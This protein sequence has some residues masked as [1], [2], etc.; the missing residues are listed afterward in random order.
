ML[1]GLGMINSINKRAL[2]ALVFLLPIAN[3]FAAFNTVPDSFIGF[4]GSTLYEYSAAGTALQSITNTNNSGGFYGP[5]TIGTDGK[6]YILRVDTSGSN[7][8]Y[9]VFLDVYD[10]TQGWSTIDSTGLAT[11]I[12]YDYAMV[13]ASNGLIFIGKQSLVRVD[14]STA[15]PTVTEVPT[16]FQFR[17]LTLG[18]NG[19]LYGLYDTAS[20]D[21]A[22]V[23]VDPVSLRETAGI[24]LS[25]I[26][27]PKALA[28]NQTGEYF[29]VNTLHELFKFSADGVQIGISLNYGANVSGSV[30]DLAITSA[31][32]V[33]VSHQSSVLYISDENLSPGNVSGVT[34]NFDQLYVS[35]N[36]AVTWVGGNHPAFAGGQQNYITFAAGQLAEYDNQGGLVNSYIVNNIP[37]SGAIALA[38]DGLLYAMNIDT[39]GGASPYPYDIEVFDAKTGTWT[40]MGLTGF[41]VSD[42][43]GGY[44]LAVM[45]NYLLVMKHQTGTTNPLNQIIA[46]DRSNGAQT[47]VGNT[48][49]QFVD[50]YVSSDKKIYALIDTNSQLLVQ[51]FDAA[52]N[53]VSISSLS[54]WYT[55]EA[56]V[57]NGQGE[58][59]VIS[60]NQSTI[61][62]YPN[63]FTSNATN[64][65]PTNFFN[66]NSIISSN[67]KDMTLTVAGDLISSFTGGEIMRI[68]QTLTNPQQLTSASNNNDVFLS[69]TLPPQAGSD[70]DNDGMPDDW[71]LAHGLSVCAD[72]SC[73]DAALD[74]D[75]DGLINIDEYTNGTDP[76]NPDSDGDFVMDGLEVGAGLNP[77]VAGDTLTDSDSDGFTDVQEY[78]AGTNAQDIASFPTT[79]T[80]GYKE[81]FEAGVINN[82]WSSS[83]WVIDHSFSS[84]GLTSVKAGPNSS[85]QT[86]NLRLE[87]QFAQAGDIYFDYQS[88]GSKLDVLVDSVL[89]FSVEQNEFSAHAVSVP[90]G[91]HVVEFNY[92]GNEI[93]PTEAWIDNVRYVASAGF[94]QNNGSFV[95]QDGST[96]YEISAEGVILKRVPI[97]TPSLP[98]DLAVTIDRRVAL[99]EITDGLYQVGLKF[100]DP[101]TAVWS[102]SRDLAGV[103]AWDSQIRQRGVGIL[104]NNIFV[105]VGD[106]YNSVLPHGASTSLGIYDTIADTVTPFSFSN[107]G[108]RDAIVG[109]DGKLY[110]LRSNYLVDVFSSTLG[111]LS[112]LETLDFACNTTNTCSGTVESIAVSWNG[113]VYLSLSATSNVLA[114]FT[115]ADSSIVYYTP[116]VNIPSAS[117]YEDIDINRAGTIFMSSSEGKILITDSSL[118]KAK[119]IKMNRY[120]ARIFSAA[121]ES[122][123]VDA[124]NDGM[125]DG[126]E[127]F[128][129]VNDPAADPDGD[130][131]SNL[132]EY[133]IYTNPIVADTD[134]DNL[135]DGLELA[136][137]PP[138]DPLNPDSD[139]DGLLD[140]DEVSPPAGTPATLP[141]NP[142]TD[143]DGLMD[144]AE[145]NN[146]D[147]NL[148]SD[149]T[150]TDTDGDQLDDKFEV[151]NGIS[152]NKTDSDG[153]QLPDY[154][155][156]NYQNTSLYPNL[157]IDTVLK[158]QALNP[159]QDDTTAG[160]GTAP[161]YDVDGLS[162]LE[163][164]QNNTCPNDNDSDND[165][166]SDGSE[167]K[168]YA[169]DPNNPDT[170]G[171]TYLDGLEISFAT[172]PK[173]AASPAATDDP[174]M[175]GLTMAQEAITN[176]DP[177]NAADPG[178]T[179]DSDG[180]GYTNVEE[181]QAGTDP[182]DAASTPGML[183]ND[184]DGLTN[185]QEDQLGTDKNDINDPGLFA[186]SDAD[187]YTN[188]EESIAGTDP[189]DSNSFPSTSPTDTD[190][191]GYADA[192]E[193]KFGTAP[194]D[195]KSPAAGDDP[196]N[197]GLTM[198]Q[199]TILGT[200][201]FNSAS[202]GL[203]ADSDGD[204]YTNVNET[205]VGTDPLD[206]NSHP[207]SS[208]DDGDGLTNAEEVQ[209]GTNP[210]DANDPGKYADSDNDGYTNIE[211]SQAAT[212]PLSDTS[213]PATPPT[214]SDSDGFSDAEEFKQGTDPLDSTSYPGSGN[215]P[216][217]GT[218]P[219][220]KP[221]GGS[222][223]GA[224]NPLLF[225]PFALLTVYRRRRVR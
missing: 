186:D 130:T 73:N 210:N 146:P 26:G 224:F 52:F 220:S 81:S 171:D 7:T 103:L 190:Q 30:Y 207:A 94:M 168:T 65:A 139:S 206:P 57:A 8:T 211:E 60:Q 225:L 119:I 140:G 1:T 88:T 170:D 197:D 38:P 46:I 22:V 155:E 157:C 166:E 105:S 108:Y 74:K 45:D 41:S 11:Q 152:P 118:S 183:D 161:D 48:I 56:I 120:S 76:S 32:A 143:G 13:Y 5:V 42:P 97:D 53:S 165:G 223:S 179:A 193:W 34:G 93:S 72:I 21:Y 187:G 125:S 153:D 216:G 200:E 82:F 172:D 91:A 137:T 215:G 115:R 67:P 110:M 180:D 123:F 213:H 202:P 16:S 185:N 95:V 90:A 44:G 85:T 63:S 151:D 150:K 169:T 158:G 199:E 86:S 6:V 3:S 134:Q 64:V 99:T 162:N 31:G 2:L 70:I 51:V 112:Y 117:Y 113:D 122:P 159:I 147:A 68:S 219:P 182:L 167:V 177:F 101:R 10:A 132:K 98:G 47:V 136:Q 17:D 148:R 116:P 154:Y 212:D 28:V 79:I 27:Y 145:L 9:P 33:V 75:N 176:T 55:V 20:S 129:G 87:T 178:M 141:M 149:P 201:P 49:S 163:E 36:D 188:K 191:D 135:N 43:S 124:D 83:S 173:D 37:N 160:T 107:F 131:L 109:L 142:D 214:D 66:F 175:D 39:S 78:I 196:D 127:A 184:G 35:P 128:Y 102:P 80:L 71:E 69:T 164:Y 50:F 96:L 208:D 77:N 209:L 138:T 218:Q 194:D 217:T 222:G 89:Q 192:L 29:V 59:Y 12:D 15:T 23:E 126:W 84:D 62:W 133:Q 14:L 106:N 24:L 4:N 144:G 61:Y 203:N 40:P 92:V 156:V 19:V 114:K 195:A 204:G 221:E 189:L 111:N 58:V 18:R 54:N 104:D 25:G 181:A 174:D 121:N 205:A 198:A 100:F